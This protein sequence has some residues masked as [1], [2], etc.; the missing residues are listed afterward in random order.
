MRRALFTLTL[1]FFLGAAF[2]SHTNDVGHA[3]VAG[4]A[5]LVL[6]LTAV[7]V[8]AVVALMIIQRRPSK[9]PARPVRPL[10]EHDDWDPFDSRWDLDADP[11]QTFLD[12]LDDYEQERR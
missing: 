11:A 3:D 5:V 4:F 6:V 8:A 12:L 2:A 10:P 1:V 9:A 7:V